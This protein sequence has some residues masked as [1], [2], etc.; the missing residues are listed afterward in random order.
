MPDIYNAD[1][2]QKEIR[3]ALYSAMGKFPPFNTPHEGY[4]ILLEEVDELWDAIKL[5]NFEDAHR[6]AIHVGAMAI[7]FLIDIQNTVKLSGG[8]DASENNES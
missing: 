3:Y 2:A 5:N 7:R 8:K 4:A 6:E 1:D